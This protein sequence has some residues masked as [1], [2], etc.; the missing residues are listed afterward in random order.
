[1]RVVLKGGTYLNSKRKLSKKERNFC[2]LYVNSGDIRDSAVKAG[3]TKEPERAGEN[4]LCRSDIADEIARL[5]KLTKKAVTQMATVGYQRLAFGNIADA[6][7]LLYKENP[8]INELKGM[9]LFSVSEIK[10]PKDGAM[11]IKFFDRLKALEKLEQSSESEENA[12]SFY[13]A[14]KNSAEI[15]SKNMEKNEDEL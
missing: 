13:D 1:M 10:R 15:L 6:I 11:E 12:M 5:T 3:Y 8:N 2:S 9:D 4:L 14:I 7:S